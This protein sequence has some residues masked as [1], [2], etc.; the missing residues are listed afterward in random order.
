ELQRRIG[1]ATPTRRSACTL[2]RRRDPRPGTQYGSTAGNYVGP[3]VIVRQVRNDWL[4]AINPAVMPSARIQ[5]RYPELFAP[6]SG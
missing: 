6:S 3:D 5:R 2:V 4:V 1:C